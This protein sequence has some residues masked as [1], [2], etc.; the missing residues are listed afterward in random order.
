M[1]KSDRDDDPARVPALSAARAP[2]TR[3]LRAD[4]CAEA[5]RQA[6]RDLLA[7]EAMTPT[8]LARLAGFASPNALYN[9]LHGRTRSLSA[10]TLARIGEVLPHIDLARLIAPHRGGDHA[11]L[12]AHGVDPL[13]P[14]ERSPAPAR[15]AAITDMLDVAARTSAGPGGMD[16]EEVRPDSLMSAMALPV[17]ASVSR[18]DLL[19]CLRRLRAEITRL[20]CLLIGPLVRPEPEVEPASCLGPVQRRPKHQD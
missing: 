11:L 20:E 2:S 12:I 14:A 16:E 19:G 18:Q 10:T 9:F 13:D 17:T 3:S 1:T 6:L 15:S 8:A 5:R 7:R 4:L